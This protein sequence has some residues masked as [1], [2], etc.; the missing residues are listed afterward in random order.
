MRKTVALYKIK[1]VILLWPLL[2]FIQPHL[3][4]LY[5]REHFEPLVCPKLQA[6]GI[7]HNFKL[8][9]LVVFE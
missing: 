5:K 1:K 9:I 7:S 4:A 3:V 2:S 6:I 8:A